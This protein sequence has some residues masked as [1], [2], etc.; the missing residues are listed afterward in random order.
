MKAI[1]FDTNVLLDIFVFN[2]F[3]AIHLKQALLDGALDA[4]ATP[5]TLEE[6]ADVIARPLFALGQR[7]QEQLLLQWQSLASV[8][9]DETLMPSPWRCQD[10]D[11]QVFLDL[12][13]TA[14]P[15]TLFSKDNEVLKFAASAA[16][17]SVMIS[18]DYGAMSKENG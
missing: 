3:R 6:F 17:E 10:P 14:K 16:K 13:Y 4:L 15:C 1:V 2:D 8:I 11:D 7:D 9:D 5:K 12:A 18:A